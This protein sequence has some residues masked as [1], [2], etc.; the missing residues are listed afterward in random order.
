L[1]ERLQR[2]GFEIVSLDPRLH[3]LEAAGLVMCLALAGSAITAIGARSPRIFLA[4]PMLLLIPFINL[5]SWVLSRLL[6]S[7]VALAA[8]YEVVARKVMKGEPE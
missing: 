7:W 6:P 8:G 4:L 2:A 1:I 3:S 5:G